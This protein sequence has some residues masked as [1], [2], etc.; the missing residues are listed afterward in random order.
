MQTLWLSRFKAFH[1]RCFAPSSPRLATKPIR[2]TATK[3]VELAP[4]MCMAG[5]MALLFALRL[6]LSQCVCFV[7]CCC[8]APRDASPARAQSIQAQ[9]GS[10][11]RSSTGSRIV[12]LFTCVARVIIQR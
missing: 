10:A 4:E 9:S 5:R 12:V 6:A 3:S 1:D 11:T 7:T 8:L 2:E